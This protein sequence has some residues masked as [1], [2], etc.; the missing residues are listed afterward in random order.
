[1]NKKA[2]LVS[3]YS[4]CLCFLSLA[5]IVGCGKNKKRELTQE[6]KDSLSL[7]FNYDTVQNRAKAFVPLKGKSGGVLSIP[8]Y[9]DP[10]SFNPITAPG[11]V[12]YMYEGLVRINTATS[13]P[14]PCLAE[15][16]EVSV[17][18][19]LWTFHIRPGVRW[20]DSVPFS[21]Y[22]VAFTFNDVIYNDKTN[23][24]QVRDI[25][26]I[27]GQRIAVDVLD[28]MTVQFKLPGRFAPLLLVLS[29]EI[30]PLHAY[31]KFVKRGV[32]SDSLGVTAAPGTMAG[33]G[34]F[35]LSSYTPYN[36]ITFKKNPLYWRKD[37][38]GNSLPYLESIIYVI[39]SNLD[40]ALQFFKRG[41]TDYLAADGVDYA[42]L[43]QNDSGFIIHQLG[44]ALVSQCIVFNQNNAINSTTGKPYVNTVKQAWFRNRMF[45]KAIAHAVDRKRLIAECLKKRGYEQYSPLNPAAGRYY[46]PAVQTYPHDLKVADSIL[47]AEG[48]IDVNGDGVLEDKDRNTVTFSLLINTGNQLRRHMAEII[49]NDLKTLGINV[50]VQYQDARI[51]EK[52]IYNPPYDWDMALVGFSGGIDPHLGLGVWHSA[53][54]QHIWFPQ[55]KIPST[56]WEAKIDEIFNAA[57]VLPE[58]GR[59]ALY[60]EW[61]RIAADELP[62]IYTVM[63]E[64]IV[65]ISK[66]V[67]NVNPSVN[68]G[69]LH[70][71]E[72]LYIK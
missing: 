10:A 72:E 2:L 24:N 62:L 25:F 28:S 53:G 11:A 31:G 19:L 26:T 60:D 67:G 6:E 43:K 29:Q 64:R 4:L 23:P 42:E 65:C 71:I 9:A 57:I 30:L 37:R 21:A 69:L 52:K 58:E 20:S 12:P 27:G 36:N 47:K 35:I 70:N 56:D 14:E 51:V 61:Q 55:Q 15:H 5:V 59:K 68:G 44:P 18:S 22:D 38:E 7:V 1:M 63:S 46:N 41:E 50:Q 16:W 17:D 32:F 40:A 49:C 54:K 34:P 45:R 48:F 8:V 39:M 3:V 66:R 33:T 13:Q